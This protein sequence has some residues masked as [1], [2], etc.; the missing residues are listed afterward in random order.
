MS[1]RDRDIRRPSGS[2]GSSGFYLFFIF[3]LFLGLTVFL[4]VTAPG[5]NLLISLI[6][7]DSSEELLQ[8]LKTENKELRTEIDSL[9]S[10]IKSFESNSDGSKVQIEDFKI[11]IEDFKWQI[12]LLK[13]ENEEKEDE[14]N[15]LKNSSNK[16]TRKTNSQEK[17]VIERPNRKGESVDNKE[18]LSRDHKLVRPRGGPVVIYPRKALNRDL[19]GKVTIRFDISERGIPFNIRVL[20]STSSVF[21]KAALDAVKKFVYLPARAY[22]GNEI[23]VKD[24]DY[25]FRFELD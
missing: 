17:R 12:R 9:K 20:S 19:T 25:P 6:D 14:L 16:T 22:Q 18:D 8:S 15:R 4:L 7:E 10:R 1:R 23:V 21:D 24:I 13:R 11:Q 2:T 5:R 3:A